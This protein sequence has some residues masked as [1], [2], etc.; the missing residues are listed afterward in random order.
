MGEAEAG[1]WRWRGVKHRALVAWGHNTQ[2]PSGANVTHSALP[3]SYSLFHPLVPCQWGCYSST[4]AAT[5]PPDTRAVNTSLSFISP[6]HPNG[7]GDSAIMAAGLKT[8]I[9]LSFVRRTTSVNLS[10]WKNQDMLTW[11]RCL[12]SDSSSLSSPPHYGINTGLCWLWP[13]ISLRLSPIGSVDDAPI[14]MTLWIAR[15]MPQW[16]LGDSWLVSWFWLVSVSCS[17]FFASLCPSPISLRYLGT[18]TDILIPNSFVFYSL[19]LFHIVCDCHCS[20]ILLIPT[21]SPPRSSSP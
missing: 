15:V 3:Q 1:S 7:I 8:I 11:T 17:S 19:L 6:R 12:L 9:A 2:W 16:T 14:Q 18:I 13:S 5:L 10:W 21:S 4:T 20:W